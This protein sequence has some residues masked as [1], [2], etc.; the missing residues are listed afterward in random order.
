MYAPTI[1]TAF[2]LIG[3]T[4]AQYFTDIGGLDKGANVVFF[5]ALAL[6]MALV[7]MLLGDRAAWVGLGLGMIVWLTLLLVK[8]FS[9]KTVSPADIIDKRCVRSTSSSAAKKCKRKQIIVTAPA[10]P[11]PKCECG[12]CDPSTC[13]TDCIDMQCGA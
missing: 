10:C 1:I 13:T 11:E 9:G 5:M 3:I 8:L 7:N 6:V 12:R 2:L 4:T